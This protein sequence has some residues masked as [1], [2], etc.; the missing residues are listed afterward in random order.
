MPVNAQSTLDRLA[1]LP[2]LGGVPRAQL[3]WLVDHATLHRVEDG[4]VIRGDGDHGIEFALYV[5]VSGRFS[6]RVDREGV[7]REVR[8]VNAGGITG[9]LPF[10]RMTTPSGYLVADGPVE[11]LS[12]STADFR[13]LTR[14]CFEFTSMCVHEMLDRVR[15][16]KA[17]DKRLEKMAALGRLSA[18]LAHELNNPASGAARAAGEMDA[19]REELKAAARAVGEAGFVGG[20]ATALEAL[21]AAAAEVATKA[22]GRFSPLDRADLEDRVVEWLE[23]RGLD[24]ALAYPLAEAGVGVEALDE[25]AAR[26]DGRRLEV[27]LRYAAADAAARE[28][29]RR[30][31]SAAG[32]IHSLVAAVKKHTHMDRGPA[33]E[34]IAL[35]DHLA[36]AVELM[37]AKAAERGLSLELERD[38]DA[39]PVHGSVA[40]LNQVWMNLLDNAI[41]AAASAIRISV[42]GDRGRGRVVVRV[43]DD[44]P[45]IPEEDRERVFEPFFTTR[46]VGAGRGLGLDVVR[47]VVLSHRGLVE[48]DSAPGRTEFRVTLPAV[49]RPSAAS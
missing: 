46:D 36:D 2:A 12:I 42:E 18:G 1:A 28:L 30:V 31:A 39:P 22:S 45:G 5:L 16:F 24:P 6:V 34:S 47:S 17:D 10:S 9:Q 48:L 32:R 43:V 20:A 15:V 44:G 21:Q 14:E 40:E 49:A 13:E 35:G 25:A 37:G 11:F 23:E 8:E 29:I 26:L 19:A 4:T 27:A 7:E 33:V 3:Q 41:A 38:D